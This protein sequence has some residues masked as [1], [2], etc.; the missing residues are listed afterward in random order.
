MAKPILFVQLPNDERINEKVVNGIQLNLRNETE[1]EYHILLAVDNVDK[2]MVETPT[3]QQY[4]DI[5]LATEIRTVYNR[6]SVEQC[7]DTS[8]GMDINIKLGLPIITYLGYL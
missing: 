6:L 1:N 3:E 5:V 8:E 2:V 7:Y 4:E